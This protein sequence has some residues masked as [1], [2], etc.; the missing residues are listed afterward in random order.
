M[1][2]RRDELEAMTAEA[3]ADDAYQTVNGFVQTRQ[4]YDLRD[5][6][7]DIVR[8]ALLEVN[9]SDAVESAGGEQWVQIDGLVAP[10]DIA[11]A[12]IAELGLRQERLGE[13]AGYPHPAIR[14]TTE[15]IPNE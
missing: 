10:A 5:R 1:S 12:V 2:D 3:A 4:S 14:Y 7:T 11:D 9:W 13:D 15:W 6:I 8:A